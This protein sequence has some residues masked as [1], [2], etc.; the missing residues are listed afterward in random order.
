MPKNNPKEITQNNTETLTQNEPNIDQ[1]C[2]QLQANEDEEELVPH[3][4][5]PTTFVLK[6]YATRNAIWLNPG[7]SKGAPTKCTQEITQ[8]I[9]TLLSETGAYIETVCAAVGMAK[10]TYYSWFQYAE[11]DADK[12]LYPGFSGSP[13][14]SPYMAF[15]N[16]VKQFHAVGEMRILKEM[17][18]DRDNKTFAPLAWILERTRQDKYGQRQ[19]IDVTHTVSGPAYPTATPKSHEEWLILRDAERKA[20]QSQ[21]SDAEYKDAAVETGDNIS[22]T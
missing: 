3:R 5:D 19:Q 21:A 8:D 13:D 1:F 20:L 10:P 7:V 14:E 11:R 22:G 18:H 4:D 15:S 12:G 9:C 16:A 2:Q 6:K 17:R